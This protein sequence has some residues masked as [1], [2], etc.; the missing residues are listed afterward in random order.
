MVKPRT[1]FLSQEM[2]FLDGDIIMTI[3]IPCD[4]HPGVLINRVKCD[5]LTFSSFRIIRTHTDRIALC[6]TDAA[7]GYRHNTKTSVF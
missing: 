2:L 4:T 6:S 5:A 7:G 1:T 3:R